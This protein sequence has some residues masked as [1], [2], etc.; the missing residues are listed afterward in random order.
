MTIHLPLRHIRHA[1]QPAPT[2]RDDGKMHEQRVAWLMALARDG[3]LDRGGY[4]TCD[5]TD[6]DQVAAAVAGTGVNVVKAGAVVMGRSVQPPKT[7]GSVVGW[8]NV[9]GPPQMGTSAYVVV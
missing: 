1:A 9:P 6:R 2:R 4:L 7:K 8:V 3:T 5:V